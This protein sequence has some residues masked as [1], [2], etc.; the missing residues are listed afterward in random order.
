MFFFDTADWKRAAA[1]AGRGTSLF[2]APDPA[3]RGVASEIERIRR[4][5][6]ICE[7]CPVIQP[8][9]DYAVQTGSVG[10]WGKTT[11]RERASRRKAV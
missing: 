9:Y 5:K 11:E 10:I 4:A 7:T 6:A 2:F 3:R 1:C 8:C